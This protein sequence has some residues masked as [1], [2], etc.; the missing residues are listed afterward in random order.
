MTLLEQIKEVMADYRGAAHVNNISQM[1]IERFPNIQIPREKL[2]DKVSAILSADVR[3][4][5]P[6][7][8]FS[9]VKS[10]TGGLKRGIYKL[11]KKPVIKPVPTPSPDV[12]SQ[13]TGKAGETAVIS[14]LLFYGFNASAM[15]VDDGIDVIAGKNNNYF[16]IQVKTSNPSANNS[17][18]FTI[19][20]HLLRRWFCLLPPI[21]GLCLPPEKTSR[22]SPISYKLLIVLV[23]FQALP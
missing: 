13:Y 8:S 23:A 15:A 1:L 3:K 18:V 9:K 6:K 22:S 16:H 10:K 21:R 12:S 2:P 4:K 7:A 20:I 17:F 11:K 5:R 19:N 14:E